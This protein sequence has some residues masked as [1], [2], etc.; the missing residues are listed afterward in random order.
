MMS[1][2]DGAGHPRHP[3]DAPV[4]RPWPRS[5]YECLIEDHIG[6][7]TRLVALALCPAVTGLSGDEVRARVLEVA[8]SALIGP[9][10]D[11]SETSAWPDSRFTDVCVEEWDSAAAVFRPVL[12]GH[13]S[14]L[15]NPYFQERFISIVQRAL[16]EVLERQQAAV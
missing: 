7:V 6:Q 4:S 14:E 2:P 16:E 5:T 8:K 13:R 12:A 10:Q 11:Q 3:Q 15:A 9:D 1:E